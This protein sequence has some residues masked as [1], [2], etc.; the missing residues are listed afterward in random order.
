M[1]PKTLVVNPS[2][3]EHQNPS[4]KPSGDDDGWAPSV[5]TCFLLANPKSLFYFLALPT[6]LPRQ[7][8]I[9]LRLDILESILA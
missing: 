2:G 5:G 4:C 9:G 1:R 6:Y 3:D 7:G 8:Y